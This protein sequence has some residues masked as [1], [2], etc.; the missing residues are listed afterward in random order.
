MSND[1]NIFN[2][3]EDELNEILKNKILI[4]ENSTMHIL[5]IYVNI[6]KSLHI[7]DSNDIILN[8]GINKQ[9]KEVF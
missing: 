8:N 1:A 7:I 3:I 4:K 6:I 5:Q 2:E 9:I